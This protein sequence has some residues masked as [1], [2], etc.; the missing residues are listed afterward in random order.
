[1]EDKILGDMQK[2]RGF[3]KAGNTVFLLCAVVYTMF[4]L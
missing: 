4:T 3:L 2:V 1:M